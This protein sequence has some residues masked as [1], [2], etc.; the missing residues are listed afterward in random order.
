MKAVVG[1]DLAGHYEWALS[2]L[3]GLGFERMEADLVHTV[4]P[5]PSYI[6]ELGPAV[7]TTS[8]Y[9]EQ[10]RTA[11]EAEVKRAK[12]LVCGRN[13][14]CRTHVL[15]GS[16]A[17]LLMDC[18]DSWNSDL[19]AVGSA[20]RDRI[21]AA[22]FGSVGR[23][24][25]VS[26]K[27]SILVAKGNG[28]T[29]EGPYSAVFATDHSEYANRCLEKLLNWGPKGLRRIHVVHAYET[30]DKELAILETHLPKG[31]ISAED[32]IAQ[33]TE[34][35]T[36]AAAQRFEDAGI[37]SQILVARGHANEVIRTE[38]S[39]TKADLLIVGAQGHGFLERLLI[40]SV[41]LHQ[42][43]VEPYSVLVIRS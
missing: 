38:M 4:E 34:S 42:V 28:G 5:L 29:K 19:I 2:M 1:I 21:S 23:A 35:K 37:A 7:Y 26:A 27:Q 32:W 6:P 25:A 43:V 20:K 9:S 36:K 39:A 33:D 22:L 12:A 8:G 16:P 15:D 14:A 11:G 24:L 30:T 10:L 31:Y 40:G 18:A 3:L 13:L 41:S 17:P